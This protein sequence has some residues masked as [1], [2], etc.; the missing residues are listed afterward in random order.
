[1]AKSK[2]QPLTIGDSPRSED[3]AGASEQLA[4]K[5]IE[6]PKPEEPAYMNFESFC[7]AKNLHWTLRARLEH[8]T[9]ANNVTELTMEAWEKILKII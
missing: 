9:Q 6:Q 8:Y 3:Q 4:E 7:S 1:M 2:E 5:T